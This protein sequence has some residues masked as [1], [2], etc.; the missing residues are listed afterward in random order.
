MLKYE[1]GG[2]LFKA[3]NQAEKLTA[4]LEKKERELYSVRHRSD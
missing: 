3:K 4:E 1:P 2:R